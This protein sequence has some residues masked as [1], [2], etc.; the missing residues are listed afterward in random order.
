M[1]ASFHA[2]GAT[3]RDHGSRE[4]CSF[5][6]KQRPTRAWAEREPVTPAD[7]QGHCANVVVPWRDPLVTVHQLKPGS[8]FDCL[9]S[10]R[11]S[12]DWEAGENAA[13]FKTHFVTHSWA[14]Q[15]LFSLWYTTA[16]TASGPA[17][18]QRKATL[19][20]LRFRSVLFT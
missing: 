15:S 19:R 16:P 9:P 3:E 6:P 4:P 10:A 13:R 17:S 5:R 14:S 8:L 20:P 7:V 18:P 12:T 11:P 2:S 1:S